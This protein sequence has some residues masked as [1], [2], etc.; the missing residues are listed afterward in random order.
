LE[1]FQDL[2]PPRPWNSLYG[3][4]KKITRVLGKPRETEVTL[5]LLQGFSSRGDMAENLCCE[6]LEEKCERTLRKLKKQMKQKLQSLDVRTLRSR[7]DFLLS[8]MGPEEGWDGFMP[9]ADS[10]RRK[11]K[12]TSARNLQP[13]LF[14]MSESSLERARRIIGELYDPIRRFSPRYDLPGAADEELH[15]LR[16]AAKKMRYAMEIFAPVWPGGLKK[17][18]ALTRALQDAGGEFQDWCVLRDHLRD[19]IRDMAEKDSSNMAFQ[20]QRLLAQVENI[21]ADL[22]SKI[23]PALTR[24]QKRLHPVIPNPTVDSV[25]ASPESLRTKV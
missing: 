7:V 13:T 19:D 24:L 6:Y 5:A 1:A 21:K 23:L 20:M 25:N 2:F 17:E 10:R 16:I 12:K 15:A 9:K 3:S 14:R 8:G 18:I 11:S 4:V 22:R